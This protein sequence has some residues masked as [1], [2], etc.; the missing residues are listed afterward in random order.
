VL[1]IS[2]ELLRE[3]VDLKPAESVGGGI[4]IRLVGEDLE[5]DLS[6]KAISELLLQTMLPRYRAIVSGAE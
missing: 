1:G 6:D 3:G 4:R 5:I 2:G